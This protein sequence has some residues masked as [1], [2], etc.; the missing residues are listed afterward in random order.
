[1]PRL[2]EPYPHPTTAAAYVVLSRRCRLLTIVKAVLQTKTSVHLTS[3]TLYRSSRVKGA[4][5]D[6]AICLP[7]VFSPQY[8]HYGTFDL[9]QANSVCRDDLSNLRFPL[10]CAHFTPLDLRLYSVTVRV[11][12]S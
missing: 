8:L 10:E 6:R 2:E 9:H 11:L 5:V 4:D 3:T 1:M 7:Y 12:R